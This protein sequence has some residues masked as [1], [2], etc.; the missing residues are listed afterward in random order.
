MIIVSKYNISFVINPSS[1]VYLEGEK[2][3]DRFVDFLFEF[4]NGDYPLFDEMIIIPE[5]LSTVVT[6][7]Q[8]LISKMYPDI[9][10]IHDKRKECLCERAILTPK[11]DQVV[12]I[13]NTLLISFEGK[14]K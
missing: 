5:N 14:E 8:D 7:V 6:T 1:T 10:H 11:D 9:A 13:N 3:A 2:F 4:D 12:A